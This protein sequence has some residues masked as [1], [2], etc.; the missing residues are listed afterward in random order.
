MQK[1]TRAL[2]SFGVYGPPSD[3]EVAVLKMANAFRKELCQHIWEEYRKEIDIR[4]N[5]PGVYDA[6]VKHEALKAT[7]F[8]I[9]RSIKERNSQERDRNSATDEDIL[10][11]KTAENE[12]DLAEKVK[13][14]KLR[15]WWDLKTRF[16]KW[17]ST[18][19]ESRK[20]AKTLKSRAALL[21]SLVCPN[22][23]QVL[24]D[25]YGFSQSGRRALSDKYQ[26]LGLHSSIRGE[27]IAASEIKRKK[28]GPG[29]RYS[30]D[31]EPE[32]ESWTKL[33]LQISKGRTVSEVLK[34]TPSLNLTPV[35]TN[36]KKSGDE[37]RYTVN[38]QIGTED[39]PRLLTYDA[40]FHVPLNLNAR[41]QR[42]TLVIDGNKRTV[43]P[44]M[45]D[46][47][48]SKPTGSGM[49]AY[50]IGW[51]VTEEGVQIAQFLGTHVNETLILPNWL[52]S[53][54]LSYKEFQAKWDAEANLELKLV[55]YEGKITGIAGAYE[56]L[57]RHDDLF[58]RDK[59]T[60]YE[61]EDR[62]AR[63]IEKRAER[64]ILKIYETA[65]SR[66]CRLHDTVVSDKIQI[67]N[68]KRSKTRDLTKPDEIAKSTRERL[69]SLA[70][71]KL[72]A[73]LKGYGLKELV[74]DC[75]NESKICPNCG[76]KNKSSRD[77][78]RT[79]K[80]CKQTWDRDMGAVI[81]RLA[82]AGMPSP[83]LNTARKT[84]LFS[85]YIESLGVKTGTKT[86]SPNYRSQH[87][88]QV[89]TANQVTMA[90]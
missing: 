15:V 40:K 27:I 87:A 67:V 48:F 19:A 72:Q 75:A 21:D 36:H 14:E 5:L 59:I 86:N 80:K 76:A 6:M 42:W 57:K 12:R 32:P 2:A 77:K 28:D 30:Y 26:A 33:T 11:L 38:H 79:C 18:S 50:D 58:I 37:S 56:F 35:Y 41:I 17:L 62:Q 22:E 63:R 85:T 61:R 78:L 64:A 23:F 25:L 51:R 29:I 90:G 47:D 81:V 55:G 13:K 74:V 73:L 54:R 84:D 49:F 53:A 88:S 66:V 45:T 16:S 60:Q 52:V 7:V 89:T 68:L 69:Q 34:G 4:D 44:I 70:P 46:M 1:Q 8:A 20:K 31:R 24:F 83:S 71:G 9:N 3:D 65:T 82:R 10:R 43:V 39:H